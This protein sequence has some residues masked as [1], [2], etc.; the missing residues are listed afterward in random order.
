ML[1]LVKLPACGIVGSRLH[2]QAGSTRVSFVAVVVV[3]VAVV[4]VVVSLLLSLSRS[5]A[6]GVDL[7]Q[8][9]LCL[10]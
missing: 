5:L 10:M 3:V 9:T 2:S 7:S 6:R 8:C 1:G 4:V